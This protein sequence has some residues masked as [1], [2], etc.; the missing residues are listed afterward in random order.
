V[1]SPGEEQ[2]ENYARCKGMDLKM[3]ERRLTPNLGYDP[4]E[5][6]EPLPTRTGSTARKRF[7]IFDQR[8]L[9]PIISPLPE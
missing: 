4:E 5:Q 3:A 6:T 7:R 1:D 2:V 8:R 9:S